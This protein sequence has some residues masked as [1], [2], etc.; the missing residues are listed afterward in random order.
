MSAYFDKLLN[1]YAPHDI[2]I[3]V[4]LLCN[5]TLCKEIFN[6]YQLH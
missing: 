3:A 6:I 5:A 2:S 4:S 1:F